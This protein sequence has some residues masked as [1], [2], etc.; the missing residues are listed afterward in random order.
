MARALGHLNLLAIGWLALALE[1]LL[2][3]SRETGRRRAGGVVLAAFSLAALAYSEWYLAIMG[4]LA[5]GSFAAFE[6]L[7][8][9][10]ARRGGAVAA[11]AA[12]GL[13]A[14]AAVAPAAIAVARE[15]SGTEGHD[16]RSSGASVTSLFIPSPV[17]LFSRLTPGLTARERLTP[18]EGSNYLG[19]V[20][21]AALLAVAV[22]RRRER[23]L[24]FAVAAGAVSLALSLGP[25]LWVFATPHDVPLPYSLLEKA[26]PLLRLGG[27]TSRF[28]A[29]AFLP[30]ALGV[31][32]ATTRL[33][34]GGKARR[35]A[36]LSVVL[37]AEFAPADPGHLVWP[38]DPPDPA[39]AAI[40]DS[41]VPGNVFDVDPGNFDMIHQLQ[42]GRAQTFGCLSRIPPA[43]LKR[44][45]EDPVI[46]TFMAAERP[47][48]DL[49]PAI[50]A[51][52]LRNR[53][54]IAFVVS[55]SF[56]QF[57]SKARALGFPQIAKSERGDR[58]VVFR[59][60]EDP[61]PVAERVDFHELAAQAP[62][63]AMRRGIFAEGLHGPETPRFEGREERG[64]WTRADM[65]L[66]V[67]LAPGDYRLRLAAPGR[68][69]PLVTVRWGKGREA[70]ERVLERVR[71]I[72]LRIEPGDRFAD[73][74]VR[75][76][77]HATPTLR[78][79]W[80]GGRELGVFLISLSK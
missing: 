57:E 22:G 43:A 71:E 34:A 45:W 5:A 77:L 25:V 3:A 19:F 41:K 23:E 11:L 36:A 20:P 44:R 16:P 40:A 9:P 79:A 52:W 31:A 55:P 67:P 7:R 61:L 17:Q 27:A 51:A 46:G 39:M 37:A 28:Q 33:L 32:F 8:A 47:V 68:T 38:F 10:R 75:L 62:I 21:L 64:C 2:L 1:G 58:A 60:P 56:P 14:I 65:T 73:G 12:S 6:V 70:S 72:P 29:L 54:N 63:A 59:V 30:L 26:I 66:F 74:L 50:A 53:W 18:E 35:V 13:L 15:S 42:H 48:P 69:A 49:P 24:D 80:K 76:E 78:E 4:V